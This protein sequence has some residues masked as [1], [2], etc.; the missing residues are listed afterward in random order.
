MWA[1]FATKPLV[2]YSL[3]TQTSRG[4]SARRSHGPLGLLIAQ[5]YILQVAY[6]KHVYNGT[7]PL[8]GF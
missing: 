5:G 2:S 1:N 8:S 4:S 6:S 7:L 3:L